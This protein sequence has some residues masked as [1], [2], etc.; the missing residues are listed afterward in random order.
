MATA[1]KAAA[2]TTTGRQAPKKNPRLRGLAPL[3]ETLCVKQ[4]SPGT[5]RGF[6]QF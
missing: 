5:N 6:Y 1:K 2:K 4:K 3:C